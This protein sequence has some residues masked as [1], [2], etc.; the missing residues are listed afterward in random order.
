M[1]KLLL[2][3][4]AIMLSVICM[5]AQD[6]YCIIGPAVSGS[7][8]FNDIGKNQL[9]GPTD[10][11][12]SITLSLNS[13]NFR[14][15]KKGEWWPAYVPLNADNQ[16]ISADGGSYA[17]RRSDG[18]TDT[19]FLEAAGL[20]TVEL[21]LTDENAPMVNISREGQAAPDLWL[22]GV[23]TVAGWD[24]GASKNLKMTKDGLSYKWF[25]PLLCKG[26]GRFVF[27]AEEGKW[28]PRYTNNENIRELELTPGEEYTGLKYFTANADVPAFK[29]GKTGVYFVN[30]DLNE[31]LQGGKIL[32]EEGKLSL[33]GPA[34]GGWNTGIRAEWT[35]TED[36]IYTY[37][38]EFETGEFRINKEGDWW[39]CFTT[40]TTGSNQ[41][42]PETGGKFDLKWGASEGPKS[43]NIT[44]AGVYTLTLDMLNM[45][46]T[47]TPENGT[48]EIPDDALKALYICGNALNGKEGGWSVNDDYIRP[49]TA[50]GKPG[51]FTWVGSMYKGEFK[52]RLNGPDSGNWDGFKAAY[53]SNKEIVSGETYAIR[54]SDPDSKFLITAEG[55]YTIT[56]NTYGDDKTMKIVLNSV[57][58]PVPDHDAWPLPE[59]LYLVGSSMSGQSGTWGLGGNWMSPMTP[60]DNENEFSWTGR[61]Y[62]QN[63]AGADTQFKILWGNTWE[64]AYVTT[65]A[66]CPIADGQTYPL[67]YRPDGLVADNKFIVPVQGIYTL[68]VKID[69]YNPTMTVKLVEKDNVEPDKHIFI[70]GDACTVGWNTGAAPELTKNDDGTY[71]WTGDLLGQGRFRFLTGR[72][73]YPTY[74]TVEN[75]HITV[76][77]GTYAIQYDEKGRTG[78]PSF[79]IDESGNYTV[80]LNI[81][82]D[83]MT[84]ELIHN[85]PKYQSMTITGS[86]VEGSTAEMKAVIPS[87]YVTF[88]KLEPGTFT[89]KGINVDNEPVEL[90]LGAD[91]NLA[92]GGTPITVEQSQLVRIALSSTSEHDTY[93]ILP[94]ESLNLKGSVVPDRGI[95][96][97]Y[98]GN[99]VWSSSVNFDKEVNIDYPSHQFYFLF[100][101][102]EKL[103][104]K[105]HS[106]TNRVDM[107]L[108]G[109]TSLENIRLNPGVYD[110]TLDMRNFTFAIDGEI[111]PL[112]VCVYGSSVA[113]GQGAD[114]QQGYGYLYGEQLKKRYADGTSE[115]AFY[116]SNVSIGGNNTKDLH[117]RYDDILHD[118]GKYVIIGL[119]MGNEG[120]HDAADQ[121]A[122]F[123]QFRDNMLSLIAKLRADGKI[124]VV[125]NN[126][127]RSDYNASDYSYIRQMNM[128]IHSW[129][130]PSF[131]SLGSIDDGAG[132]WAEGYIADAFHPNTDGHREFMYGFVPSLFDALVAGKPLPVRD[133]TGDLAIDNAASLKLTPEGTVH[134]FT[135]SAR[136]KGTGAGNIISFGDR[137]VSVDQEGYITYNAGSLQ[138]AGNITS[139]SAVLNDGEWHD[140]ALS[141]YYARGA[142][143][144]YIDGKPAGETAER[145]ALDDDIRFG[146]SPREFSEINF[147]R[148]GMNEDEMTAHHNGEM[149]K[150]SLE[151]YSPMKVG[152]DGKIANLAQSTNSLYYT[153]TTP[154]GVADLS[155]DAS[156]LRIVTAPGTATFYGAEI[157]AQ[158]YTIDGRVAAI[159]TPTAAGNTINLCTGVYIAGHTR[160]FVR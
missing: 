25:G 140:I 104:V 10:G 84:M 24:A 148:A 110:I 144:L 60:T 139:S 81:N 4:F 32:L 51:E 67:V 46:L 68:T 30:I 134:S 120:I 123:N 52:F 98:A 54:E 76:G 153:T 8:N 58:P 128:L 143:I 53:D 19:F 17:A 28:L 159:V 122:I 37:T 113:N 91:G 35:S 44:A 65:K 117:N 151:V 96:I 73:W 41:D 137:S 12:Y 6:E 100:N 2:S 131:N 78:E 136:V 42:I 40:T 21:D 99:G 62:A 11:K 22:V 158:V 47:V 141:H 43:F 101:N 111:D 106:G 119:S 71:T 13:G 57:A 79:R 9:A 26:D 114:Y 83:V 72:N 69:E 50:T 108:D 155:T 55:E 156:A 152:E 109:H 86:A 70:V 127:T 138:R 80:I 90:G 23:G 116:T 15:N 129:D 56:V 112:R 130:V 5:S 20:Y 74:T 14:I 146:E 157:P 85:T 66:N 147:W 27:L 45:K 107:A 7:W 154:S 88:L 126:Y 1:K 48:V 133:T 125:V 16:N 64:P 115:N 39:P 3:F 34:A 121:Q 31:D 36:G 105:R 33:V 124:P 102:D 149:L 18:E 38:G 93:E 145:M 103:T 132:H 135:V 82:P 75:S 142:S 77:P 61:L 89:F 97:A 94:I 29:V 118:F 87:R 59:E 92:I 49:M 160:F 150:S 63:D 95:S